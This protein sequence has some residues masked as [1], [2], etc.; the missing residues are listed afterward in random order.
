MQ[1]QKY[2]RIINITS[3]LSQNGA[4]GYAA[5]SA[6]NAGLESLTRTVADEEYEHGILVN[7]YNPGT[8]RS[9]MHAI[10]KESRT[11]HAGYCAARQ[12]FLWRT[13]RNHTFLRI[14]RTSRGIL[15]GWFFCC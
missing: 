2:G 8:L 1:K 3:S 9:D 4:G 14:K 13:D 15:P 12:S 10:G 7:L 6:A 11:R 5:Y